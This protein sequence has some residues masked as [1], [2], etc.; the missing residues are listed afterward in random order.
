[1]RRSSDPLTAATTSILKPAIGAAGFQKMTARTFR[2]VVSEILQCLEIQVSRHGSR[3]FCINWSSQAL[4]VPRDLSATFVGD[5]F[6][7]AKSHGGW[8]SS[9]THQEA[10]SS[11]QEAVSV[12]NANIRPLCDQSSTVAGTLNAL[13]G[14]GDC[15]N[16]IV[17]FER[18]AC[19]ARLDALDYALQSL[20]SAMNRFRVAYDEMPGRKWC[21]AGMEHCSSLERAIRAGSWHQLLDEWVRYSKKSLKIIDP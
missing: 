15:W 19:H 1:M 16:G 18:A 14:L 21:L 8:W 2:R 9:K 12:F 7:G 4:F 11:M 6:P 5:R 3:D 17:H 10:E 13:Q 20:A